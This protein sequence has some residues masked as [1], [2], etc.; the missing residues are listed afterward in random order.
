PVVVTKT[1]P[2]LDAGTNTSVVFAKLAVTPGVTYQVDLALAPGGP[3]A[4]VDDN[5]HSAQF[6]VNA[7]TDTTGSG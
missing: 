4:V 5:T 2:T 7:S 6:T 1:V 3:D